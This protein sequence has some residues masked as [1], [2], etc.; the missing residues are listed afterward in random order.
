[1]L[2][3]IL[4]C[5]PITILV[6]RSE[7]RGSLKLINVGDL[8][9]AF[10]THRQTLLE[11]LFQLTFRLCGYATYIK[12]PKVLR[13]KGTDQCFTRSSTVLVTGCAVENNTI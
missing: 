3:K 11:T 6:A 12:G 5:I 2:N 4:S 8:D 7:T 10:C 13:R 1:M 9:V